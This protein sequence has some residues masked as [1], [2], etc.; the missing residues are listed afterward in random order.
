MKINGKPVIDADEPL[1]TYVEIFAWRRLLATAAV[2]CALFFA[3]GAVFGK[4]I[5]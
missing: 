3:A 1:P 4:F 5:W 2:L